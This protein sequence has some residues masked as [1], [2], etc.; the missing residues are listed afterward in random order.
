MM[1]QNSNANVEEPKKEEYDEDIVCDIC[2]SSLIIH[3][4]LKH[5]PKISSDCGAVVKGEK[6]CDSFL[7]KM[8]KGDF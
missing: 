1:D 7:S 2:E 3:K 8:F 5:D 6:A 4:K